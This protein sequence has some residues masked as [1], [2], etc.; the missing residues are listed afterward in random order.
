M[1]IQDRMLNHMKKL[2]HNYYLKLYQLDSICV[3]DEDGMNLLRLME[4]TTSGFSQAMGA[5]EKAVKIFS[6]DVII[7]KD[8][9]QSPFIPSCLRDHTHWLLGLTGLRPII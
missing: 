9:S 7:P 8:T 6:K 1:I 5:G 2:C 4:G 3:F